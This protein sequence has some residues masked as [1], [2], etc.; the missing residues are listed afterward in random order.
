MLDRPET[1]EGLLHCCGWWQGVSQAEVCEL[2]VLEG[3]DFVCVM[4]SSSITTV[5]V[6][7]V[8]R[9]SPLSSASLPSQHPLGK[10]CGVAEGEAVQGELNLE[11]NS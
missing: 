5:C 3:P 6:W 2:Q 10:G 1:E 9:T 11:Q 7:A 8:C 4:L